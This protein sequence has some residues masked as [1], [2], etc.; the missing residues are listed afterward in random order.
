MNKTYSSTKKR[1]LTK[2][3]ANS[4]LLASTAFVISPIIVDNITK[5]T[6]KKLFLIWVNL[7]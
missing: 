6:Q 3:L 5:I 7:K 4:G 2:T 1:K